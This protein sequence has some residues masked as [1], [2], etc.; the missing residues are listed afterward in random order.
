MTVDCGS[1]QA[2]TITPDPC[3]SINDVKV[4]GSFQGPI[5]TYTFT[6]VTANHTISATFVTWAFLDGALNAH[7]ILEGA[8][9][10]LSI[11]M[12]NEAQRPS[13]QAIGK[14]AA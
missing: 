13:D 12:L 7:Q 2:F 4:D 6:N 8:I 1:N 14:K 3:Y 5:T 9:L 11:F 10:V